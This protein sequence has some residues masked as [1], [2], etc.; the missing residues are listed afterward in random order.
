[1][2]WFFLNGFQCI[3]VLKLQ[4][5]IFCNNRPSGLDGHLGT[6]A[7]RR[8]DGPVM[9][10]YVCF[11]S[12][13]LKSTLNPLPRHIWVLPLLL[14]FEI[15]K[16]W[17]HNITGQESETWRLLMF[18]SF[19]IFKVSFTNAQNMLTV[20]CYIVQAYNAKVI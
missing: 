18:N 11:L 10:S 17:I 8:T 5:S 14:S 9:E 3:F 19:I 1:M 6:I 2:P 12:F 13:I 7:L 20:Y 4:I 15:Q 16:T